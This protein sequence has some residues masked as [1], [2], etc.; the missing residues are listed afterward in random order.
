MKSPKDTALT[1]IRESSAEASLAEAPA[2][3]E[4]AGH[5][6]PTAAAE[7]TSDGDDES[8]ESSTEDEK[9][10]LKATGDD[11]ATMPRRWIRSAIRW[12]AAVVLVAALAGAGYEGWLLF[13]QH[14]RGVAA[15]QALDAARNFAVTLTSTDP[16]AIDQNVTDV[17]DGATGDFKDRYTK[18]SSQLRKLLIDNKVTTHGSVVESAVKSAST[19]KVEVLLVIKQSVSNSATPDPRSDVTAVTMTMEMVNGRWLA[20]NVVLPGA[21]R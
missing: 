14:Q 20:S 9:E 10:G 7:D 3:V 15:R 17:L 13:Q 8:V 12:A 2:D 6:E 21:Q 18:A 1:D 16:N 5:D 4:A 19:N 11:T